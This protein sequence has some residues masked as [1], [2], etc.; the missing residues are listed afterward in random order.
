MI[1]SPKAGGQFTHAQFSCLGHE[2]E[3]Q[4]K[5]GFEN[6]PDSS[7]I[8]KLFMDEESANVFIEV[9]R[10]VLLNFMLTITC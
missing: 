7:T 9:S 1:T 10:E 8:R 4:L 6:P 5:A 3:L 2:W